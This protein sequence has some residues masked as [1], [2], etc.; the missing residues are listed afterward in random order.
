MLSKVQAK[1][2]FENLEQK[3]KV[4]ASKILIWGHFQGFLERK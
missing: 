2:E 1:R 4:N 3:L